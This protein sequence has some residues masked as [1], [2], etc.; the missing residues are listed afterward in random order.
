[1]VPLVLACRD[2][3]HTRQHL[4]A[5]GFY[6]EFNTFDTTADVIRRRRR[7]KERKKE[8][9]RESNGRHGGEL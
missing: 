6:S 4:F 5:P 9:K 3:E 8:K 7:K 1:M 2:L